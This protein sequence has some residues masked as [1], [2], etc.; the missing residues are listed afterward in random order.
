MNPLSSR[1]NCNRLR[2][3]QTE[4]M[5]TLFGFCCLRHQIAGPGALRFCEIPIGMG[6]GRNP[7]GS[8]R[9]FWRNC[10]KLLLWKAGYGH[11]TLAFL[12]LATDS[13]ISMALQ[14][15]RSRQVEASETATVPHPIARCKIAFWFHRGRVPSPRITAPA[16]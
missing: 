10:N 3:P 7:L 11:K 8:R 5:R 14:F 12:G 15:C 13:A 2:H 9:V 1:R 6:S 16:R 4:I